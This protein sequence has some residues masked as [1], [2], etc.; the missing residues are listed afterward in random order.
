MLAI[1]MFRND[2]DK[3]QK[4]K[5]QQQQQQQQPTLRQPKRVGTQFLRYLFTAELQATACFTTSST[6]LASTTL[7]AILL[8]CPAHSFL[9]LPTLRTYRSATGCND[10]AVKVSAR[11]T[12]LS[13][14]WAIFPYN[15]SCCFKSCCVYEVCLDCS[16]TFLFVTCEKYD[17]L[18]PKTV[19]RHMA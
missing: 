7:Q 9:G 13:G 10:P 2:G 6:L 5:Q 12:S 4:S 14:D 8:S 19:R 3:V 16:S 15:M 1:I 18:I 11:R 17:G